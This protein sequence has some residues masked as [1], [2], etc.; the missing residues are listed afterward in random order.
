MRSEVRVRRLTEGGDQ[1]G[2][3]EDRVVIVMNKKGV[4]PLREPRL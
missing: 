3:V 1:L 2:V 4:G